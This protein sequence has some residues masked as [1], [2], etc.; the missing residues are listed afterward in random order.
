MR[1]H[2]PTAHILLLLLVSFGEATAELA[3]CI[4]SCYRD[5]L[6]HSLPLGI[7]NGQISH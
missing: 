7:P 4:A 1:K 5:A 3:N 2:L 6:E